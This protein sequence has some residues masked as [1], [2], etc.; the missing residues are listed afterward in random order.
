MFSATCAGE[1]RG[2]MDKNG[3]SFV[4][5]PW[6]CEFCHNKGTAPSVFVR[7]GELRA[8]AERRFERHTRSSCVT[9]CTFTVKT[10]KRRRNA[11]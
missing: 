11:V 6:A 5:M 3:G 9:G 2:A 10:R 4:R 7:K 1:M 8:E